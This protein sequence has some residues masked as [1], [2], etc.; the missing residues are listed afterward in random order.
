MGVV[1]MV[2]P[3]LQGSNKSLCCLLSLFWDSIL[4]QGKK[5]VLHHCWG[6]GKV[7]ATFVGMTGEG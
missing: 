6:E 4:E 3:L 5:G 2:A 1:V 7:H